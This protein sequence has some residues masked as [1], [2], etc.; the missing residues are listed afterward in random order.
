MEKITL[1]NCLWYA[2]NPY[3]CDDCG[4]PKGQCLYCG[5]KWYEH[6]LRALPDDE[7]ESARAIQAERGIV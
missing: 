5:A 3:V 4:D 7:I 6:D 1:S 2:E